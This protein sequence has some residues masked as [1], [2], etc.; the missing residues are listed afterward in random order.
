MSAVVQADGFP[1]PEAT[2]PSDAVSYAACDGG[3]IE[4]QLTQS[5]GT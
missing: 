5:S 4:L 2:P 1:V 3:V